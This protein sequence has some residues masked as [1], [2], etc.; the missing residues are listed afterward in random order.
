MFFRE[1]YLFSDMK[2]AVLCNFTYMANPPGIKNDREGGEF[3]SCV[4]VGELV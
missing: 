4:G 2:R 1:S 3:V